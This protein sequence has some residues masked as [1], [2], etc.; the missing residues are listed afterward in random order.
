MIRPVMT[1]NERTAQEILATLAATYT[2]THDYVR[3]DERNFQHLDLKF[4][5][6]TTRLLEACGFRKLADI[7]DRT[8]TGTPGTVLSAIMV[9]AMSARDGTVTAAFYHPHVRS[10]GLRALLWLLRKLPGRMVDMET[11][12]SDGTFVVTSTAGLAGAFQSPPLIYAEYLPATTPVLDLYAKHTARVARHLS[13]RPGVKA[14]EAS[15]L[16]D[17]LASQHRMDAIK[18]AYRNGVGG[19]TREELEKLSWLGKEHAADVHTEVQ[20]MQERQRRAS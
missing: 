1:P 6:R 9:R 8:V 11:E 3:V 4:Y 13:Q 18:A 2:S 7:E 5:S 15:T 14:L 19:V 20:K 16:D 10:F 17:L 12:C